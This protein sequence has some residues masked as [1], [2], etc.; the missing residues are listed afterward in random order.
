LSSSNPSSS[1]KSKNNTEF[2][3]I[4]NLCRRLLNLNLN[5]KFDHVRR[6]VNRVVHNFACTTHLFSPQIFI[7]KQL[8]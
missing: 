2:G 4:I 3:I 6:Q 7:L 1:I 5:S 8:L